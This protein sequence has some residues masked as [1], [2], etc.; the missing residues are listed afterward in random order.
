M[1]V[2]VSLVILMLAVA[3]SAQTGSDI[4]AELSRTD[5]VIERVASVVEPSGNVEAQTMLADA[6]RIQAEAWNAYHT[7]RYRFALGQTRYA[8]KKALD[9]AALVEIS[10][11]RVREELRLTA[12]LMERVR[13]ML[14]RVEDPRATELWNM[15]QSEQG[16]AR[17]AY[18][19]R[20]YRR[21]LKFTYAARM[22]LREV[23]GLLGRHVNPD[24]IAAALGKTERLLER[25][26]LALRDTDNQRVLE[27]L[28]KAIELQTRARAVFTSREFRQALKLTMSAREM[29]F[30]A[31][32]LWSGPASRELVE[33]ALTATQ[34]MLDD[35]SGPIASTTN[36]EAA[37][38]LNQARSLQQTA[39]EQL[40]AGQNSA[41]LGSTTRARRLLQRAIELIQSGE[42]TPAQP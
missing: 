7:R 22:H 39:T 10:P 26:R 40:A 29:A 18:E 15:A 24:R 27:L 21:A 6:R 8:R 34:E 11:E 31:L 20:E 3:A 4:L 16:T 19:T 23:A 37:N 28:R 41:A 5:Q 1:K 36:T 32:E 14:N 2:A 35:W 13:L 42:T 17:Q 38:L 12:E 9:A 30:R 33:Q 25:V